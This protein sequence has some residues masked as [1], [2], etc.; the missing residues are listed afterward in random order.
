MPG[1]KVARDAVRFITDSLR[2]GR[3]VVVHCAGG[4][5]RTGTVLAIYVR[6]QYGL[7]G[8]DAIERLR[9]YRPCFVETQQQEQF[10]EGFLVSGAQD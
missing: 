7:S 6:W 4:C 1:I 9:K 2:S 5:G 8:S 10:V 3:I